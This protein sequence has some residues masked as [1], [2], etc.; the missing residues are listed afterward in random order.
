MMMMMSLIEYWDKPRMKNLHQQRQQKIISISDFHW[1]NKKLSSQST[2]EFSSLLCHPI[3]SHLISFH[4]EKCEKYPSVISRAF[5]YQIQWYFSWQLPLLVNDKFYLCWWW[6]KFYF[7]N[8]PSYWNYSRPDSHEQTF[9]ELC[10]ET[11]KLICSLKK[12]FE[13]KFT[14]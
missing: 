12:F 10:N 11:T 9:E 13:R 6:F 4:L 7:K 5:H 8:F 14:P 3:Q 2:K 1:I